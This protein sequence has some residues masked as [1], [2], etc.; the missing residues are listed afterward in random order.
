MCYI[1][2]YSKPSIKIKVVLSRLVASPLAATAAQAWIRNYSI[3]KILLIEI[4]KNCKTFLYYRQY[5]Q[6]FFFGFPVNGWSNSEVF[7]ARYYQKQHAPQW[8]VGLL[9]GSLNRKFVILWWGRGLCR[10]IFRAKTLKFWISALL[11]TPY[12]TM[13]RA[14]LDIISL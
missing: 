11:T 12:L 8:D 4:E 2:K 10:F 3:W 13:V 14:I 7:I 6:C 5:R 9:G 1:S